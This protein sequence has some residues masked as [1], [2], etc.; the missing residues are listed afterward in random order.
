MCSVPLSILQR[1][2][3]HGHDEFSHVCCDSFLLLKF[4][5]RWCIRTVWYT[6][7]KKNGRIIYCSATRDF[8][9]LYSPLSRVWSLMF[10]E[11]IGAVKDLTAIFATISFWCFVFPGM[12]Q[13]IVLPSKLTTAMV[14]RIRFDRLVRIHMWHVLRLADKCFCT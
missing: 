12:A 3:D 9:F 8:S 1:L 2:V 5:H 4:Y 10:G 14:A 11:V 13:P 7:G 6:T